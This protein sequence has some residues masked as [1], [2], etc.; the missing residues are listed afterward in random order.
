MQGAG[1]EC[2][3][4]YEKYGEAAPQP[5]NAATRQEPAGT[6]GFAGGQGGRCAYLE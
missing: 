1:E 5:S 3:E 2:P 4:A 6:A